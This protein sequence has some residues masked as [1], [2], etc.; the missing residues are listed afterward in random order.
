MP[1]ESV[2][3]IIR[4]RRIALGL[5][6]D[7]LAEKANISVPFVS[8]I[9][10]GKRNISMQTFYAIAQALETPI[11]DFFPKEKRKNP[12]KQKMIAEMTAMMSRWSKGKVESVYQ[13]L[14]YINSPKR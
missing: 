7:E 11:E 10:R 14:N 6:Q 9:E 5:T 12:E 3:K 4:E 13:L 1:L 8:D 2:P